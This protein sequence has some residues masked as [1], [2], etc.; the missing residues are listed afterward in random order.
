MKQ[1]KVKGGAVEASQVKD[2]VNASYKDNKEAP[3]TIGDY[4]LDKQLSTRTAKVYH[5]PKTNKTVVANR[6]TKGSKD[7]ANN[8]A[9]G[10]DVL[11]GN[12]FNLYDKTDRMKEAEKTQKEAIKKY[13]KV[14]TN[15][16]HSQSGV[17]TRKLNK[18]GLTKEVININPASYY[19]KPAKN[20]H[21]YR[22]TF[23]PVSMFSKGATTVKDYTINP[24]KA[25]ST[26][27]LKKFSPS[28]LLGGSRWSDYVKAFMQQE[29][30]LKYREALKHPQLRQ[31][32]LSEK[33]EDPAG[34]RE[35][36]KL[37]RLQKKT[38]KAQ[39]EAYYAEE[40]QKS[41]KKKA[42]ETAQRFRK[43]GPKSYNLFNT[44]MGRYEKDINRNKF[45]EYFKKYDQ[46]LYNEIFPPNKEKKI[47]TAKP[48]KEK[49]KDYLKRVNDLYEK[50]LKKVKEENLKNKNK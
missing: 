35:K 3:K 39:K 40:L 5:D 1:L 28:K 31:E 43:E 13:G 23:D 38:E 47:E 9:Y 12:I 37:K 33:D 7:W 46:S 44:I 32:W 45:K 6:G 10:T 16:G 34:Y 17:I 20:E 14:D 21:T 19:E 2:L 48:E 42:E 29:N 26:E 41:I 22:S 49:R 24:L 27:F 8:L 4:K 11:T 30:I 25:H 15:V 18:K 36:M 50:E